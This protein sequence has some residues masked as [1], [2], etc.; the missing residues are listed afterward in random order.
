MGEKGKETQV[1]LW[2]LAVGAGVDG[3]GPA[4]ELCSRRRRRA[5]ASPL[6]RARGGGI[7]P[8]RTSEPRGTRF[9]GWLG[10]R[11][12]GGGVSMAG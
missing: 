3:G 5:A 4:M 8:R 9:L 2:V 6:R 7:G 12:G 1:D 10:S 11:E